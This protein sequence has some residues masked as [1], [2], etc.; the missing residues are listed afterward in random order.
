[1]TQLTLFPSVSGRIDVKGDVASDKGAYCWIVEALDQTNDNNEWYIL[2][3]S[4]FETRYEAREAA[5]S[6]RYVGYV[7][8]VVPYKACFDS[9]GRHNRQ[10]KSQRLDY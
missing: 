2:V 8:R 10:V 1:M 7:T 3:S 4:I 9:K 6:W 5:C